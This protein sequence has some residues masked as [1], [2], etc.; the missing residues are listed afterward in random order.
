MREYGPA[1]II[2][3]GSFARGEMHEASDLDL[4]VIK[5]TGERFF[6]RIGRVRDACDGIPVDVQ[7][8][9]Y[10]PSELAEMLEH[11]NSFLEKALAEGV[12]AYEA[13]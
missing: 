7:P 11:G 10:T 4:I 13:A 2:V 6:R 3:F 1:K 12:I 9:V 5:E 8:F